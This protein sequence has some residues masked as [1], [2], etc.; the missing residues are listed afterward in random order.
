MYLIITGLQ[1]QEVRNAEKDLDVEEAADAEENFDEEEILTYYFYCDCSYN[2][3]LFL[4][5]YHNLIMSYSTLLR[6]L[7]GYGLRRWCNR[8]SDEYQN[9]MV[10]ARERIQAIINGPEVY[11]GIALY[12]ILWRWKVYLF[13]DL[14]F[15]HC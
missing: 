11:A 4:E 7:Q 2:K 13:Q 1:D 14:L 6:L 10:T 3:V 5:K 15:K 9:S 12:G 8:S